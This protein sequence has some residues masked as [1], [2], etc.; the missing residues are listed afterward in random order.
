MSRRIASCF[1]AGALAVNGVVVAAD[2]GASSGF[3]RWFRNPFAKEK[4]TES[5]SSATAP[6]AVPPVRVS[7]TGPSQ[8]ENPR[9]PAAQSVSMPRRIG[10]AT[11]RVAEPD[12]TSQTPRGSSVSPS[13]PPSLNRRMPSARAA[14]GSLSDDDEAPTLAPRLTTSDRGPVFSAGTPT[15]SPLPQAV[16]TPRRRLIPLTGKVEPPRARGGAAAPQSSVPPFAIETGEADTTASDSVNVEGNVDQQNE[17]EGPRS[18]QFAAPRRGFPVGEN[19]T[20]ESTETADEAAVNSSASTP[21]TPQRPLIMKRRG[22][23]GVREV[24]PASAEQGTGETA[25]VENS[26]P[27][28]PAP[29]AKRPRSRGKDGGP[30]VPGLAIETGEVAEGATAPSEETVEG[31]G[32]GVDADL[33]ATTAVEAGADIVEAE[34]EVKQPP[35]VPTR[36]PR[37]GTARVSPPEF[38]N[39]P[40][41]ERANTEAPAEKPSMTQRWKSWWGAK[42]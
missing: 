21:P 19:A 32:A 5:D 39:P 9:G 31:E 36:S 33:N 4:P 14:R 18:P 20:A 3:G 38:G 1:L 12:A 7:P 42:K 6:A 25:V 2:D 40:A 11:P 30:A 35:R 24:N 16:E 22:L 37:V 10:A 27:A 15:D 17:L 28:G 8:V 13:R 26:S 34:E 29:S 23:F 41:K